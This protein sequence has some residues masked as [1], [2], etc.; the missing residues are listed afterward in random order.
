[1]SLKD[2]SFHN[3]MAHLKAL[4]LVTAF[5]V[6]THNQPFW[7]LTQTGEQALAAILA[8]NLSASVSG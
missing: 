1:M 5:R 4:K 2:E 3:P 8:A 6:S 7:Q